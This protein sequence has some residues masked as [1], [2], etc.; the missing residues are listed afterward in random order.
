MFSNWGDKILKSDAQF[1]MLVFPI[2]CCDIGNHQRSVREEVEDVAS[3]EHPHELVDHSHKSEADAISILFDSL[4]EVSSVI[5][6]FSCFAWFQDS[7]FVS[8]RSCIDVIYSSNGAQCHV[9]DDDFHNLHLCSQEADAS[10]FS[11]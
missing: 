11:C 1:F 4:L 9:L 5:F 10:E 2:R 8:Q 6:N 7:V 3:V